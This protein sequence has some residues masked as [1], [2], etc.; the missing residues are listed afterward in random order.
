MVKRYESGIP[1]QK[2][3]DDYDLWNANPR[4]EGLSPD[5]TEQIYSTQD[6]ISVL[7]RF[8]Q[9]PEEQRDAEIL[10]LLPEIGRISRA[11]I[12]QLDIAID[13]W[14]NKT[15]TKECSKS[16]DN[17]EAFYDKLIELYTGGQK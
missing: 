7:E 1:P 4:I 9:M 16:L 5:E 14:P 17:I 3:R 10:S 11:L 2:S 13:E 12:S 6:S 15:H 8:K